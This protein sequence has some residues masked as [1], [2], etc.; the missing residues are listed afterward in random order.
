MEGGKAN[1]GWSKFL[2]DPVSDG[3]PPIVRE[4][5]EPIEKEGVDLPKFS[6]GN[7]WKRGGGRGWPQLS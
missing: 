1:E 2:V 6:L 7:N 5:F 4:T 3:T